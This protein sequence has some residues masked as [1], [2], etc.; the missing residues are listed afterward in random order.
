MAKLTANALEGFR[1]YVKRTIAYAKFRVGSTYHTV[2][3]ESVSFRGDYV[4]IRFKIE[5]DTAGTAVV[6]QCQL[7]NNDN[8]LWYQSTESLKMESVAEGYFYIVRVS[9]KE[10]ES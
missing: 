6:N 2:P 3:I 5:V 1:Q 4:E 8:Q 9:I 7:Y 10:G